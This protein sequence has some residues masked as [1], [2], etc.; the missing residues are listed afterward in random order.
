M[1]FIPVLAASFLADIETFLKSS[2]AH[3]IYLGFAIGGTLIFLI[4]GIMALFGLNTDA[5]ADIDLDMDGDI[6]IPHADTGLADFQI[7]SIRSILAFIAM[8]GWGGVIW[9]GRGWGGFIAAM[10]CGIITML[11]TAWIV[12]M[13]LKLQQSGT[14]SNSK[15]IGLTGAVYL[16]IP[17]GDAKPGKVILTLNNSTREIQ[18]IADNP[19]PTGAQVKTIAVNGNIFKVQKIES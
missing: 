13:I 6:D 7:F 3:S 2:G 17:G 9:G 4:M 14:V 8:F 5:S 11:L 16:S 15:L 12:C 10:V 19:I 1:M 18:A